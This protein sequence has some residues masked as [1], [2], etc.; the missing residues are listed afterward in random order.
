M[1]FKTGEAL[2]ALKAS[3]RICS[4]GH[5]QDEIRDPFLKRAI[6]QE[7]GLV[8][9]TVPV[10]ARLARDRGLPDPPHCL[11]RRQAWLLQRR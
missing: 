7:I 9:C 10:G 3:G 6:I 1:L 8:A 4:G 5:W 11:D 2:C